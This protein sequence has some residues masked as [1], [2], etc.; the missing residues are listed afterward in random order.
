M[1]GNGNGHQPA[2]PT[3]EQ[4][5]ELARAPQAQSPLVTAHE[6]NL[7]DAQQP[8]PLSGNP[9]IKVG[10]IFGATLPIF[11]VAGLFL[12]SQSSRKK[13]VINPA[14][15]RAPTM[16][17]S[18]TSPS[19]LVQEQRE[20]LGRAQA[21]EA[22]YNQRAA[23]QQQALPKTTVQK[24]TVRPTVKPSPPPIPSRPVSQPVRVAPAFYSPLPPVV[25]SL[26]TSLPISRPRSPV[27][28]AA[29]SPE[30]NYDRYLALANLGSYGQLPVLPE[31]VST[32]V[33]PSAPASSY[34]PA[35]QRTVQPLPTI[36]SE[37][38]APILQERPRKVLGI[39][40]KG[41]AILTT[42]LIWDEKTALSQKAK[43]DR[44]TIQLTEPL[45]AQD[46]SIALPAGTQLVAQ[47]ESMSSSGL[48][49][50]QVVAAV[51]E[52]SGQRM[53]IALPEEVIRIRGAGGQPLVAE[54]YRD[55]GGEIAAMDLGVFALGALS[56]AADQLTR[57]QSSSVVSSLGGIVSTT[58]NSQPNLLAG[59][60]QGGADALLSDL[61]RRNQQAIQAIQQQ[62]H[63]RLIPAGTNVEVYI[64]RSI[65]LPFS[66]ETVMQVDEVSQPEEAVESRSVELAQPI[67]VNRF[68]VIQ[69]ASL[70][71]IAVDP[72]VAISQIEPT[73]PGLLDATTG[74]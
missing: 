20:E 6:F 43:D 12:S 67:A 74:E 3:K 69:S 41:Q 68:E 49:Q 9:Y 19:S 14:I 54:R 70:A 37:E 66:L 46:G 38:E 64:N 11:M 60:I 22:L 18:E 15:S 5:R 10:L 33:Q 53:E 65:P 73:V 21:N 1:N 7:E 17:A 31:P 48:V 44:F 23:L 72:P 61:T 2:Q 51:V 59:A 45:Q 71:A 58:Q 42:P 39:A 16:P 56:K 27:I 4:L 35:A 25:R 50:L 52:Q 24:V 47:L 57:P 8:R 55:P 40:T 63:I 30:D 36:N 13:E 26:P 62:P 28:S 29:Q 34:Q 32:E